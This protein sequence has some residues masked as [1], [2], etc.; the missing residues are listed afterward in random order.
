MQAITLYEISNTLLDLI[1]DDDAT[2]DQ[3]QEAFAA[4]TD[5]AGGLAAVSKNL[6]A[7]IAAF[8]AEESR[9]STIRKRIENRQES[10]KSYAISQM[11]KLELT[12]L[13]SG[14]HTLKLRKNPASVNITDS[15]LI[16][17]R[18]QK[19]T[20]TITVDKNAI[21]AELKDGYMVPGAE[22]TQT[23]RLEIK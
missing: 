2:D 19:I 22:L 18:F 3:I 9:L 15:G 17:A 5:K 13:T 1:N 20:Q 7:T 21:K 6:D 11:E 23:T 16:P 14:V 12:E 4:L 10:L 8:K